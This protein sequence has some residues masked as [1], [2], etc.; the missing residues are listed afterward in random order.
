MKK[1][2]KKKVQKKEKKVVEGRIYIQATFNNTIINITDRTG[3][4][5]VWGSTGISGFKGARKATPFSATTA[6]DEVIKKGK[7]LGLEEVSV[8]IKGP[9]PGRSAVLRSLQTQGL[10]VNSISDVTPIP[11]NGV[12]PPKK[13]R[14]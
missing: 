9:G 5:V 14:V 10:R 13:R 7:E 6:I 11:H 2:T 1:H 8:Y 4:T 12:R 3:N